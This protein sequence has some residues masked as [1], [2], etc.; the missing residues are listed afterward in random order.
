MGAEEESGRR[1]G[2]NGGEWMKRILQ[3]FRTH[4]IAAVIL[5]LTVVIFGLAV[6]FQY[7]LKREYLGYLRET[8]RETEIAVLDVVQ[9]SVN[10]SLQYLTGFGVEIAASTDLYAILTDRSTAET[11]RVYLLQQR[12]RAYQYPDE[13]V[14]VAIV[15]ADGMVTEYD[16]FRGA[17]SGIA[18][19]NQENE[20]A[21]MNLYRETISKFSGGGVEQAEY[22]KFVVSEEPEIHPVRDAMRVVHVGIPMVDIGSGGRVSYVLILTL[23][24]DLFEEALE[25]VQIP[26][27][28]YAYGFVADQED[29]VLYSS[30]VSDIGRKLSDFSEADGT[31]YEVD[32]DYFGWKLFVWLDETQ[33]REHV[34]E[35]YQRGFVVYIVILAA[36]VL[37]ALSMLNRLLVPISR[38]AEAMRTMRGTGSSQARIQIDGR[39]EIWSLAEEYNHM[40]DRLEEKSRE[41]QEQHEKAILSLQ[42]A[43]DAEREAMESQISAHFIC[44]TLGIINYEAIDAGDAKVSVLIKKLSNILRYTFDRKLQEVY[45]RQEIAWI[46]QY[47]YLQKERYEE[48]FEYEIRMD[49]RYAD[50]PCE[51][52]MIQPFVENSILHAFE[53]RRCGGRI[54]ITA[55]AEGE[56]LC[57]VI[58]DNGC[59]MD[60]ETEEKIRAIIAGRG[61][62]RTQERRKDGEQTDVRKKGEE[63]RESEEGKVGG[64][65]VGIRNVLARMTM[66]YGEELEIIL[67]TKQG[68]G[69]SFTFLLPLPGAKKG[70]EEEETEEEGT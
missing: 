21:I 29:T 55:G 65:G 10:A 70:A 32:L 23:R 20:E 8:S 16:R 68:E 14:C 54:W 15:G 28:T 58:A 64:T 24:L 9:K 47:L 22:P 26:K 52:L 42:R 61:M 56:R 63:A 19:W 35:I 11:E 66:F 48:M 60:P 43:Y 33:M 36:F 39:H 25:L 13:T 50:W 34:N 44:N 17:Y 49:E 62:E 37:V 57:I 53:G 18:M 12:L 1:G 69:T 30:V 27:T 7:Y 4:L 38:I 41:A 3:Y 5:E 59:G 40:A 67:W 31:A 2:R 6:I 46:E 51:K 45:L